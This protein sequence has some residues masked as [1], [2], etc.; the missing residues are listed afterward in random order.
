MVHT[1][2]IGF[3]LGC[4]LTDFG[5]IRLPDGG[6]LLGG[7]RPWQAP[8]CSRGAFFRLEEAKRTDVYSFGMLIWRVF[9]DGDPFKS[10]G[11]FEGNSKE[12]RQKRNDAIAALKEKDQLVQ[13][14]CASLALSA[15]F[16]RPQLEMLCEI[17]SIT[18]IK[19][20]ARRELDVTRI[21]RMLTP[22]NWFRP[23]HAVA[24]SRIPA[25][26]DAQLLDL[27]KWH[28]EFANCSP[29]VKRLMASGYKEYAEGLSEQ[30]EGSRGKEVAAAYQLALCYANGFGVQ[31]QPDECLR[32][33]TFASE[34]GWQ[35]AHEAL[36]R[37]L[38]AFNAAPEASLDSGARV[39]DTCSILS[40]SWASEF[41]KEATVHVA[42]EHTLDTNGL[43]HGLA[44]VGPTSTFLNA[45]ESCSYDV[46]EKLLSS[47]AKPTTSDD[48]VSP[49]HFL[50][51]WEVAKA[52]DLG[53]RLIK[54]G[55]DV[56]TVA[57]PGNTVGGTPLMW[58]VYGGHFEHSKILIQLG[59]EPM[60]ST[61]NGED[62]LSFAA[63]LHSA[64]DLR[65]LLENTRP[66]QVRGHI[67]RLVEAAAGG[68]SRFMRMTRH[69]ERWTT[70]AKETLQLLKDWHALFPEADDFTTLL[71][72]ALRQSLKSPYGMS[73]RTNTTI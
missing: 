70:A 49:I 4:K 41:T 14:V 27:E 2:T 34:G 42:G 23:R 43:I 73:I 33:L 21:I 52:N 71:L 18:L 29:L 25:D 63:R 24:P 45:A 54:A 38:E 17:V 22:N 12:Q 47:S 64:M 30:S 44:H 11:E 36:P 67:G 50:S 65:L 37:I 15:K 48:G 31:F 13:H 6:V 10:L 26:I 51:S 62:S 39:D 68:E 16:T 1:K 8:E 28:S 59:A 55:A 40:S 9:L 57:N 35:K 46:L 58:A 20:S 3:H 19:D 66:A 60:V 56:N 72:Q 61:D 53:F 69:G 7:S 5:A 32:W